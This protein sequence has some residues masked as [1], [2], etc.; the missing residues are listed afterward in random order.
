MT[1]KLTTELMDMR[2]IQGRRIIDLTL[3]LDEARQSL[4][5]AQALI[6]RLGQELKHATCVDCLRLRSHGESGDLIEQRS[7]LL[8]GGETGSPRGAA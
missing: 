6:L 5:Q 1:A 8:R 2:V 3:E 7:G 4:D